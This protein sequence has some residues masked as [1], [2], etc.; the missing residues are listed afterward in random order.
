[1]LAYIYACL[2]HYVYLYCTVYYRVYISCNIYIYFLVH[3][4]FCYTCIC[5]LLT[6]GWSVL[7]WQIYHVPS[8]LDGATSSFHNSFGYKLV[9]LVLTP[10]TLKRFAPSQ[11]YFWILWQT[12]PC[13]HNR[14]PRL[15]WTENSRTNDW[16]V[17]TINFLVKLKVLYVC[18][19]L[20]H[21]QTFYF[22]HFCSQNIVEWLKFFTQHWNKIFKIIQFLFEG[23]LF[24]AVLIYF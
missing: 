16:L 18:V 1:M 14:Q 24:S 22:E 10:T 9:S 23:C 6:G 13:C 2:V 8:T 3:S 20:S 19:K 5:Y 21:Q 11:Q 17:A 12:K 15:G 7:R 4:C